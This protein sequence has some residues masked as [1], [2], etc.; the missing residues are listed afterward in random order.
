MKMIKRGDPCAFKMCPANNGYCC[1]ADREQRRKF[2]KCQ[3]S[4]TK[5]AKA[6]GN[7]SNNEAH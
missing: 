4:F 2:P 7:A 3:E 1:N 5:L 6:A